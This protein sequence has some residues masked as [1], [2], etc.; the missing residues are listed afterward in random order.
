MNPTF[1]NRDMILTSN[2]FYTVE[3]NDIVIV[4][5]P[6]GY[7]IIKRIIALPGETVKIQDGI[8][9]V[10]GSPV[11]EP[12]IKGKSNDM[13]ET[14]VKKG[15]YF[16]MGDNRTPGESL[17]SRSPEIGQIARSQIIGENLISI[18]PFGIR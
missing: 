4:K 14:K 18:I 12:F 1:D 15:F 13:P 7:N 11:K 8:V 5:N 9:Y 2:I 3:R 17:D 6:S 10:N 16:I